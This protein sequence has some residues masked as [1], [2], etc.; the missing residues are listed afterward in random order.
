MVDIFIREE[1]YESYK[2]W[3]PIMMNDKEI[4]IIEHLQEVRKR[5]I[6]VFSSIFLVAI[7]L[8]RK[9]LI[10]IEFFMKPMEGFKLD[11][12][13]FSLIEGF[14]TRF[15]ISLFAGIIISSPIIFYQIA[16]FIFP[17]LTKKER[18]LL[19]WGVFYL[20]VFFITGVI[21]GYLMILPTVL[22]F[23]I[24]Y[25]RSY[26]NPILSG[27]MYF[28]FIG[29]FCIVMGI[30][31][32]MPLAFLFLASQQL[33]TVKTLRKWRKYVIAMVI[34]LELFFIPAGDVITFS[35]IILPIIVLYE[36]NIWFLYF[37]ERIRTKN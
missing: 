36:L 5:L 1:C 26:M 20:S 17:G 3:N 35:I 7:I 28:S 18:K 22:N 15:K 37:K 11:F 25:S 10:L 34:G 2:R 24:T 27:S 9:I 21:C 33:V 23:L 32:V 6:I 30:V 19:F 8:Y 13:Y 29:M 14:M 16:A 12:V 31:F 4:S